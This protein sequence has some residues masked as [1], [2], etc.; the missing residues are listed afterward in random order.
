MSGP[1]FFVDAA[2]EHRWHVRARNG[3]IVADSGEGYVEHRKAAA[4]YAA[5]EDA[6]VRQWAENPAIPP[7]VRRV[8]LATLD[9]QLE[10]L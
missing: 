1:E 8:V 5:A 6:I 9:H 3:L 4:G 10:E 2:G 7:H